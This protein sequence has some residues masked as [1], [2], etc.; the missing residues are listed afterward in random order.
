MEQRKSD[1]VIVPV[2]VGNSAG[3][4][5]VTRATVKRISRESFMKSY[6]YTDRYN[7]LNK[8]VCQIMM[9]GRRQS[10]GVEDRRDPLIRMLPQPAWLRAP[11]AGSIIDSV[12]WK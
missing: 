7:T 1:G 12:T 5:D 9:M 8:A 4:K 6:S 3:R 2:K 10:S 11:V